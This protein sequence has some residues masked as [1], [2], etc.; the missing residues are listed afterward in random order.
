MPQVIQDGAEVR[1]VPV[2]QV[3]SGLVLW[4][5][6]ETWERG[7]L[8]IKVRKLEEGKMLSQIPSDE[9]EKHEYIIVKTQTSTQT[10]IF[11]WF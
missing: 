10:N 6:I 2:D 4:E 7:I 5:H 3:G 11:S 8:T 9:K 1:G